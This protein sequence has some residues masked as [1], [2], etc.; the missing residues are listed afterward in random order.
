[1]SYADYIAHH[2]ILGMKWGIRRYRNR[3]GTLTNAGKERYNSDGHVN[4]L[5]PERKQQLAKGAKLA[6]G[7]A[8]GV[9]AG[10]AISKS[11][12]AVLNKLI[13][14]GSKF[15]ADHKGDVISGLKKAGKVI[16]DKTAKAAVRAGNAALDA[17]MLSVGTIAISKLTKRFEAKDTDTEQQKIAKKVA[18]DSSVAAVN[19]FT[20]GS[21]SG[22]NSNNKGNQLGKDEGSRISSMVGAPKKESIDRSGS[23][24]QALFKDSSGNTRSDEERSIIK[25]MASAGYSID[26]IQQYLDAT[27][28]SGYLKINHSGVN[29]Y[30]YST[31]YPDELYHHGVKGMKWG[32]R[33][34]QNPDGS[35]KHPK[36][37][38]NSDPE[39]AALRKEYRSAKKDYKRMKRQINSGAKNFGRGIRGISSS[40][41]T[42]GL[43]L[44]VARAAFGYKKMRK[45]A[46]PNSRLV[47]E[48]T[49]RYVAAAAKYRG[50][51]QDKIRKRMQQ[52]EVAKAV[53][54]ILLTVGAFK[55]RTD[56]K[57]RATVS[58]YAAKGIKLA[59]KGLGKYASRRLDKMQG[60]VDAPGYQVMGEVRNIAGYLGG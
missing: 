21:K 17:A 58:K 41:T 60:V 50:V 35:L 15:V 56:P 20:K 55:L 7:F 30:T 54:K 33:R 27:F 26:Q 22:G 19:S 2:G 44:G 9:A 46:G 39:R 32:V 14:N 47:K 48:K 4:R 52:K 6:A 25:S 3:D 10:Y 16:G 51:S 40:K 31:F 28:S 36:L 8:V 37:G 34:F 45:A 38:F 59:A 42:G 53:G 23:A 57:A 11:D 43:A 1:M 49:D 18:L 12:P 24:Y 13:S 29:M 5:S